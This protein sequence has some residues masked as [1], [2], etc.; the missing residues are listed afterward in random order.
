MVKEVV[1][2]TRARAGGR[3]SSAAASS[4]A[5]VKEEEKEESKEGTSVET[6]E[7][8][9]TRMTRSESLSESR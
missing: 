6:P 2:S 7:K 9:E 8:K 3:E 4:A 5:S 1:R